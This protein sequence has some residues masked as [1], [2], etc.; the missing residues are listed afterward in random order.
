[1]L[2]LA[3]LQDAV[4]QL[5]DNAVPDL[6]G[7][8][9]CFLDARTMSQLFRDP[10]FKEVY[11]GGYKSEA[12]RMATVVEML[13]LRFITTTQAPIQSQYSN[14]GVADPVRKIRRTVICGADTLVEGVFEGQMGLPVENGISYKEEVDGVV[15]VVRPPLDRNGQIIAQSWYSV[16]GYVAPT[17]AT[18]N[19]STINTASDAYLKRSVVLETIT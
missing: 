2:T 18:A 14:A 16:I 19:S 7:F 12:Y 11:R 4:A 17:D 1:M 9:N 3:I 8:Y 5:R 13:G 6:D 15:M 10:D